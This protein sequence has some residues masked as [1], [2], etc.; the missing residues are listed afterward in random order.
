MRSMRNLRSEGANKREEQ[1]VS[2]EELKKGMTP[3][4]S[5]SDED[6][7]QTDYQNEGNYL[8]LQLGLKNIFRDKL[9]SFKEILKC[10]DLYTFGI[11][12]LYELDEAI[13]PAFEEVNAR[14]EKEKLLRVLA[15]RL[16]SRK[17]LSWFCKSLSDLV[18]VES[19]RIGSYLLIPS[20]YP[21]FISTG[22]NS[23]LSREINDYWIS[24]ASGSEDFTRKN[25]YEEQLRKCE[26][27]R[28][29]YDMVLNICDYVIGVLEKLSSETSK[30][31][32]P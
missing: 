31:E 16:N 24:V 5:A 8:N 2:K 6:A 10:I 22:R 25:V 29:E 23:K 9:K 26:D 1:A 19:K 28:F 30:R 13:D 12:T 20:D 21:S 11:I 7:S 18:H 4:G 14:K 27:E 32:D 15:S 3:G 17:Q